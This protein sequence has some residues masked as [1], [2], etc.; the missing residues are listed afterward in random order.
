MFPGQSPVLLNAKKV[1][2]NIKHQF[3]TSSIS[4]LRMFYLNVATL[5]KYQRCA[6][7]GDK[8]VEE[9]HKH[10]VLINSDQDDADRLQHPVHHVEP[11]RD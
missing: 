10:I 3:L 5:N 1:N 4:P 8:E 7:G 2:L 11:H 9:G 6:A